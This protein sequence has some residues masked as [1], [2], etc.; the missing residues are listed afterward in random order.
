MDIV[1]VL[2]R[3]KPPQIHTVRSALNAIPGLEIHATTEAG[4]MVVT[5]DDSNGYLG[6]TIT[7]I[8]NIEGVLS[9]A[10]VYQYSEQDE[11]S[12]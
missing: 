1:G 2:V 6:D 3:S 12:L 4:Q 11:E 5:L 7:Q 9:A 10:M 8:N